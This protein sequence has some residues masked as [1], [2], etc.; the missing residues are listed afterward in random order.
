MDGDLA[1]AVYKE[2]SKPVSK[3]VVLLLFRVS[4]IE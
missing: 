3:P 1:V 4:L 2:R